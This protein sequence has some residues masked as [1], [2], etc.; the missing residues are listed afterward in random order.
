MMR[1][2]T[3]RSLLAGATLIGSCGA[4]MTPV[5]AQSAITP[6]DPVIVAIPSK[7][8]DAQDAYD[9][10]AIEQ[11]MKMVELSRT[12]GG[13]ISQMLTAVLNQAAA[14]TSIRDAQLGTRNIPLFNDPADVSARQGGSGIGEMIQSALDGKFNGPDGIRNALNEYRTNYDLDPAFALKS[15]DDQNMAIAAQTVGLG[16]IAASIGE[17]S[18]K[19]TNA[20]MDRLS[21]YVATLQASADL[22]TSM[23]LNTRVLIELTQ[24]INQNTRTQAAISS[25]A[26]VFLLRFSGA[27]SSANV[28]SLITELKK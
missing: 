9:S 8:S 27:L 17:D 14:I 22:K 23:D 13:G 24:Q 5:H 16:A 11:L 19:S 4:L 6:L 18:Y 2:F 25:V 3:R 28:L 10:N 15:S 21:G 7:P 20:S 12:I 1:F 26:G